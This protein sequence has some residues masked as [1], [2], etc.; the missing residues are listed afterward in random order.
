MI[1][2]CVCTII[3]TRNC[4]MQRK[5]NGAC[6]VH[7]QDDAR[8]HLAQTFADIEKIRASVIKRLAGS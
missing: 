4:T 5:E 2:D 8:R 7:A 6:P 3:F 1:K